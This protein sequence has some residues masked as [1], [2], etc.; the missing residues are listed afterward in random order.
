MKHQ[1][2]LA[3]FTM[4]MG[5]S[6]SQDMPIAFDRPGIADSPYLVEKKTWQFETGIGYADITGWSDVPNPSVMIRKLV[7]SNDELRLTY[8]YGVQMISIIKSDF[9]KGFDHIALG[10][11]HRICKENG[12]IPES[13]VILNTF[14]PVQRLSTFS[15]SGIYNFDA[16]FQFQNTLNERFAL[17]YNLGGLITNT[18]KSG[19]LTSSVCLNIK[20]TERIS[21]FTEAFVYAP[22]Q[23][24]EIDPGFD[25]GIL[26]CPSKRLQFDLSIIDNYFGGLHYLTGLIGCSFQF[27]RS[28]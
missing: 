24:G 2:F 11:K 14:F 4:S 7:S 21:F 12:A 8:N 25:A 10:W 9:K 17:N 19:V 16:S 13:S 5:I 1:L 26:F 20:G 27:G 6:F 22:L 15:H 3:F 23:Y 28:E 18:F